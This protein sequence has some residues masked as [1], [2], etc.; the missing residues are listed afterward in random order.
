MCKIYA[1]TKDISREEWLKLRKNGIGGSDAG[2]VCGLNPYRS[3]MDIFIDKTTDDISDYDNEAMKQGRDLEDY[4]AQRFC[5]A[6]GLKVRKSNAMYVHKEHPFML[7][8]VDRLIIGENAGLECKTAS[9]YSADKWKDG[10]IP[11]H[12]FAQCYHY[13]VVLDMDAWYIAVL[14]YGKE[15]KYIRLERDEEIITNLIHIEDEFWNEQVLKGKMP[16]PD[17][18]DSTDEFIN[19]YFCSSTAE[20]SIP[21]IGFDTKLKRREE[22]TELIDKLTTEKKQIEQEVKTYM[23]D[24]ETAEDDNFFISWKSVISNKIDTSRLKLELPEVYKQFLKPSTS[25]RFSVKAITV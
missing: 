4:V 18:S 22:I 7:A 1:K 15:F 13:M 12:Y 25:R 10:Q 17:G 21:L 19:T 11:A 6:T 24:A 23:Q 3:A 5:E 16:H 9:P 14:I 8:D 20:K 2:A